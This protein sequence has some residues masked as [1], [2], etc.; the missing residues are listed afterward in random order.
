MFYVKYISIIHKFFKGKKK[1]EFDFWL[2]SRSL[3]LARSHVM[4]IHM[5]YCG[6]TPKPS[7]P[8]LHK[9][10]CSRSSSPGQVCRNYSPN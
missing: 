5:E 6:G 10:A 2:S 7:C 1:R 9:R 8:Q 3:A 4:S